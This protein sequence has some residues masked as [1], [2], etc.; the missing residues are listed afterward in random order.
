MK[1]FLCNI[2]TSILSLSIV[3]LL[4]IYVS[5]CTVLNKDFVIKSI[6][7]NNYYNKMYTQLE[8]ALEVYVNQYGFDKQIINNV[9]TEQDIKKEINLVIECVYSN[10]EYNFDTTTVREKLELNVQ[11]FLESNNIDLSS[12]GE[13]SINDFIDSIIEIYE[14][15]S[16][17]DYAMR[18]SPIIC[19]IKN[20]IN[21][22]QT[23]VIVIALL[24]FICLI[25]TNLKTK[26]EI[27]YYISNIFSNISIILTLLYICIKV[28]TNTIITNDNIILEVLNKIEELS[29]YVLMTSVI[30]LGI[31]LIFSILNL[32]IAKL[33]KS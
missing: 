25:I 24:L 2:C 9:I 20:Y 17:V 33:K 3:I 32:T 22:I 26:K 28:G 16:I 11:E 15:T 18:L 23:C 30:F 1:R 27:I 8:T 7:K 14:K 10:T 12:R 29:I 13:T 4:I 5:F 31:S 21:L 6:E 19:N